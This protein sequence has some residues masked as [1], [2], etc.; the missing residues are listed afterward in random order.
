LVYG[1][2]MAFGLFIAFSQHGLFAQAPNVEQEKTEIQSLFEKA[3]NLMEKGQW[4]QALVPLEKIMMDFGPRGYQDFGPAFGVMH[5]RYGFCLKN[6]KRFDEALAAYEKCYREGQNTKDTPKDKLNS[7]WELSLLEMGVIKQT[8]GKYAEAVK[9][10]EAFAA[11]PAAA[12]SYDEAAF[13]VQFATAYLKVGQPDRAKAL[14]EQ[15]FSGA[16]GVKPK[17]DDLFRALLVMLESWTTAG[18][19]SPETERQAHQFMDANSSRLVLG[20]Y[21]LARFEF[22]QRLLSLARVA[23]ENNQQT[24]AIRLI[25][26]MAPIAE[27]VR[28]LRLRSIK[29]HDGKV[30]EILKKEIEKYAQQAEADDSVDWIAALTLAACYKKLGNMAAGYAIYVH[31]L[32]AAPEST[33]R[34]TFLFGTIRCSLA[35]EQMDKAK[36]WATQF[37]KEFPDHQYAGSVSILM[38]E[39]VFQSKQYDEAV[40]LA[41]EIR[42]SLAKDAKERDFTDFV[43]GASLFNTGKTEAAKAELEAH[44]KRFPDSRFKEPVRYFEASCSVRLKA[45][46]EAASKLEAFVRAFPDS[47]YLGYALL[48]KATCHFQLG[49]FSQCLE[50]T[51]ILMKQRPDF[52]DLDRALALRGDSHLMLKANEQAEAAYLKSKELGEAAGDAHASVVARVLVQLVRVANAMKKQADVIAYYDAYKAKYKVGFYDAEIIVAA[53]WALEKA[54]RGKEAME[55][56]EKFN[57]KDISPS[58][59]VQLGSHLEQK[60]TPETDK[61]AVEWF[62]SVLDR[63]PSENYGLALMGKARLL[64][65]SGEEA[66]FKDA[67]AAFDSVIK[68]LKDKPEYVEEAMLEKGRLYSS[69]RM[70]AEAQL[71]FTEMTKEKSFARSRPEV[72]FR[73][74]RSYAELGKLDEALE[75]FA[76]LVAPPLENVLEYSAE[77]RVRSVEIQIQ[78]GN[79]EKAFRLA[80]DTVSK[81][82]KQSS[83]PVA[84]PHILRSKELYKMLRDQ[85]KKSA[86]PDE[87]LWGIQ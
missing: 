40:T 20:A 11:K 18:F 27:V 78:K 52:G 43:I 12:G 65:R 86:V 83:H 60:G 84:G 69:K 55:Q 50:V 28:D 17:P 56:L 13:R 41:G 32:Q 14:L 87:G 57:K 61:L 37:R 77:A 36:E 49:Q 66:S 82:Y 5:Y 16:G 35:T 6:L 72:C 4:E 63:G 10:Y 85:L 26:M 70:W 67:I 81:L 19:A 38:L 73:L 2:C 64:G 79:K 33:H 7:V 25:G 76:P 42:E 59:A 3:G 80:K 48:D 22:N 75:A 51:D 62:Q 45:W 30:P 46:K 23:S 9:D 1:L 58:V 31:G 39:S 53:L 29:Y 24:L 54:G 44:A 68:D 47:D 34:P 74:G 15:L 71:I 21:D 8:L